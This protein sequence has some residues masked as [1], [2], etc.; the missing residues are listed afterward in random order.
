MH[1]K[2]NG[3]RTQ[4]RPILQTLEIE[5]VGSTKHKSKKRIRGFQKNSSQNSRPLHYL[6]WK[7]H[8]WLHGEEGGTIIDHVFKFK[9]IK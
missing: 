4:R 5:N 3:I 1:E 6:N 7:D 2:R 8:G 9:L